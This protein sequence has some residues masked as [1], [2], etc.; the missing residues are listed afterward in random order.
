MSVIHSM[1]Q[2]F[3]VALTPMNLMLAFSGAVVGTMVGVLPGIG[4]ITGVAILVPLTYAMKLPPESAIILLAGIYYGAMYGGSTTSILLNVPGETA[5]VVTTLDGY[6]MARQ[7]RAG[8][9]LAMAAIGSFVAGTLSVLGLMLFGPF[10]AKW[11][12]RFGPAEYLALMVFAFS[13]I[14]TL[15]GKNLAKALIATLLGLAFATVGIDP[16]SAVPRYTYGQLKL[17]DGMDFLVVAIGLFAI[18]EILVLLEETHTGQT[19]AAEMGK[20][21]ISFKELM[22]SMGAVLRGSIL[23]F[24][25]GVLPGAGASIASFISYTLEKRVSNRSDTFGKGDIRGVAGPEAANNAAAG[26]ALIPLLTMGIPGSGT[27]AILLGALMGMNV[28]PGPLMFQNHPKV[29]WGLVASMYIGN[30]M[31]LILN[32]PLVGLFVKILL[33]PRWILLPVVTAVSFI[34]VYSVNNSPFDLLL[35][36]GFGLLGYLMRKMDYPL[37]PVILGLVLGEMMEKNLRR[38]LSI[39][40][41]EWSY[42]FKSPISITLW[43]LA[44]VSLFTPLIFRKLKTMKDEIVTGEEEL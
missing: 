2:G 10:L 26:G 6:Q 19:V 8:S 37:A 38:A 23:G 7:G 24:F 27:T 36:A 4:P 13:M 15:A 12:I 22:F 40:G 5:S 18:S 43:V 35:M 28:T 31:L 44:A 17:Y 30:V 41:G 34:G 1:A 16:G 11:A 39:S 3:A 21:W 25:I 9:A 33:V 29:V 32:L 14:S 42:L 20:V